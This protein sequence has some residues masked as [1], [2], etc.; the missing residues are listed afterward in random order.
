MTDKL[1]LKNLLNTCIDSIDSYEYRIWYN[2]NTMQT[3]EEYRSTNAK[4]LIVRI[5]ELLEELEETDKLSDN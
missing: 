5:T 3:E 4:E 2:A 1:K